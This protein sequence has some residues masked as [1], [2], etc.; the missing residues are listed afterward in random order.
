MQTHVQRSVAGCFTVLRQRRSIRRL[1]PLTVYQSLVLALV[2]PRLD[3]GNA[4]LV[5]L[6]TCLLNYRLQSVL[7]AAARSSAGLRALGA[8]YR[9]SGPFSLATSTRAH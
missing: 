7:N 4:T 6:P 3:Y 8:Y 2:L 9:R 1:V 5:G